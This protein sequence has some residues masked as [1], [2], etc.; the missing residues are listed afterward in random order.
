[1]WTDQ[2]MATGA[3][4][5]GSGVMPP[6]EI[7][8]LSVRLRCLLHP[9]VRARH[10]PPHQRR[11]APMYSHI[12]ETVERAKAIAAMGDLD[13]TLAV[14]RELSLDDFGVVLV[15]LPNPAYPRLSALLPKMADEQVQRNWTGDAGLPSLPQAR[16]R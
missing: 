3:G 1:V 9:H 12:K 15:T 5:Y 7:E 8:L 2:F 11:A 4:I 14:L 13:A 16:R 10:A 6:K